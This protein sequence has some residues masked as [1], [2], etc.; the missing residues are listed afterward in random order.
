MLDQELLELLSH[1]DYVPLQQDELADAL[2][3]GKNDRKKL[4]KVLHK[5]LDEG[6][7][8]RIKRDRFVLPKDADL[9]SGTIKF[10]QSGSALIV[11][12]SA[13]NKKTAEVWQVRAEDTWVALHGDRVLAR[14]A[15]DRRGKRRKGKPRPE[16]DRQFVRVIRILQRA[17]ETMPGTL[18]RSRLHHFVIPDD[19]RIIQDII[20]PPP[21]QT[22][23]F[24]RPKVDDKVIVRLLDWEQRHLNP[25][26]EII[27]V[28]GKTHEPS[29]EFKALLHKYDLSPDFPK[30][31]S[32]QVVECPS[33]V[34]PEAAEGRRD[35]RD[36]LTFTIDPDD[37]KDFDD[38]LSLERLNDGKVRIGVHIADVSAYVQS[39]TPLDKEAHKRGNSTYLVGCVIPMLPH[40][41]SNGICSLKEAEDR[42]TKS[43]FLTFS[44]NGAILETDF[45][46]TVIRS[47]KRLTYRQAYAFLKETDFDTIR[48]TPL[49]PSHQTGFS[50]RPLAE[51][52][53]KEMKEMQGAIRKLWRLAE[54]QRKARM[55]QGSL[56]L[57]M[58]ETKIF[59]D[60]NGYAD[61]IEQI[62]NDESHQLIE[63]F[64][65]MANEAVAKA[66][67]DAGYPF[68]SRVH[69]EPDPEKLDELREQMLL[70]GLD[71]GDLNKRKEVTKLLKQINEHPQGYALRIQF[72]R[73]LKQACY[74][75]AA[76]GHY[77]LAK[78]Y[79]AH[80]TSPIRRYAD[81]VVHRIFD[82]YLSKKRLPTAPQ[83]SPKP[84]NQ[85]SL[86]RIAEHISITEQNSTEAERESVKIKLLEFFERELEKKEK[87][88]FE[89]VIT[90]VR[91]HGLF[92]ELTGSMA[93]GLVHISTLQDDL[94]HVTGDGS[95]ITGRK[96]QKSFGVGEKTTV[97]V[98]RVDRFK[99]Q[100]DFRILG[101]ENK[102]PRKSGRRKKYRM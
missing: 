35:M 86:E 22:A 85:Q 99:R 76:D 57:D 52:S 13:T 21:E 73:S 38:A 27:E 23:F 74:R 68:I 20:V 29:A 53:N 51:M 48:A 69:D 32:Q 47:R 39:H 79:Y 63:E 58:P 5:L 7:V 43:V 40:Q 75:A 56:D 37:A 84:Y 100:I 45:A 94:Y 66:F 6:V 3:L 80:F 19:P 28:L 88:P 46:N 61:R 50:G 9:I 95:A 83:K 14:K 89:A 49:P 60:E 92:V 11:P 91:N 30:D 70:A 67:W 96:N 16:D 25:E 59:V 78:V 4:P 97:M 62:E 36:V 93:F 81:L 44:K 71:C 42:L 31:V 72:L 33:Q 10:R 87:T 17:R 1:P 98:D 41:L 102:A 26:G 90:E 54:K 15:D 18:K 12:E 65:L 24:P 77:G 64:M 34:A 101:T 82:V 8:A 2:E 55:R